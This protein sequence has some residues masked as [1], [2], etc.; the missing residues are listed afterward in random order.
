MSGRHR[1][2]GIFRKKIE[3]ILL[4]YKF[5]NDTDKIRKKKVLLDRYQKHVKLNRY[6]KF[7]LLNGQKVRKGELNYQVQRRIEQLVIL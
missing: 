6:L 3:L 7:V 4:I 5:F 1:V 2:F